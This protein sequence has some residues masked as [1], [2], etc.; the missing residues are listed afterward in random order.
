MQSKKS[1]I[2]EWYIPHS[3]PRQGKTFSLP[4]LTVPNMAISVNHALAQAKKGI[5]TVG[6]DPDTAQWNDDQESPLGIDL[7][8]LDLTDVQE[9][10]NKNIEKIKAIALDN[11][12]IIAEKKEQELQKLIEQEVQKRLK[13]NAGSN[14]S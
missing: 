1:E 10:S 4:S 6:N 13:E 7:K 8:R 3:A 11:Q 9:L 14:I 12:K 2:V 5:V